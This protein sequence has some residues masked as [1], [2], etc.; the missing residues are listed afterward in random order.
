MFDNLS[1]KLDKAFQL[2]KGHGR[3]TGGYNASRLALYDGRIF[4]L[5]QGNNNGGAQAQ[6][7]L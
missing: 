5:N 2:L 3:I 6:Q 4:N 1:G 7:V